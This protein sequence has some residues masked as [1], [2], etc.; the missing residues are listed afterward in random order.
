MESEFST[1][2]A[3]A[4]RMFETGDA[5]G[6][7][8]RFQVLMADESLSD[9]D[10]SV[11]AVNLANIYASMDREADAGAAFDYA[12]ALDAG[13]IFAASSKAAWLAG[14]RLPPMATAI[15]PAPPLKVHAWLPRRF[16]V[17]PA[18]AFVVLLVMILLISSLTS[19]HIGDGDV[20]TAAGLSS[21]FAAMLWGTRLA[22][23][24]QWT[25]VDGW[26]VSYRPG[27]GRIRSF[28]I[29]SI[30]S[31]R[32]ER[33]RLVRRGSS[34]AV[35][36]ASGSGRR[37]CVLPGYAMSNRQIADEF[38]RRVAKLPKVGTDARTAAALQPWR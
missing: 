7:A 12:I 24:R 1:S 5:A 20:A 17:Q 6:A 8:R 21:A 4:A 33:S 30:E 29:R 15:G 23:C 31:I 27:L 19:R 2:S 38:L 26:Q 34:Y 22:V 36:L 10:R 25:Q 32:W 13:G 14:G 9:R 11:M 37:H 28:D 3:V 35:R 18:A 16:V